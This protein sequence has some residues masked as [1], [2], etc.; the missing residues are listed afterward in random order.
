M[1]TC[2]ECEVDGAPR[3]L[4]TEGSWETDWYGRITYY[5]C[6]TCQERFVQ[7]DEGEVSIAAE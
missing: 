7:Q 1:P 4:Q 3:E 6:P 5:V 2:P